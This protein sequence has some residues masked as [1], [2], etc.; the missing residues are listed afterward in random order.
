MLPSEHQHGCIND[1]ICMCTS[2]NDCSHSPISFFDEIIKDILAR[3]REKNREAEQKP[4]PQSLPRAQPAKPNNHLK[5]L[6]KSQLQKCIG[7]EIGEGGFGKVY[8]VGAAMEEWTRC[9]LHAR[10][11]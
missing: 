11:K 6:T 8:K 9:R 10:Y 1:H 4:S 2:G 3:N 5:D 7:G